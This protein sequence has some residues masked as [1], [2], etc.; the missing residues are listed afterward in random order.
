MS[1]MTAAVAHGDSTT[2][3]HRAAE[4]R[5]RADDLPTPLGDVVAE[6]YRRRAAELELEAW[7]RDA[8]A[9]VAY[10]DAPIAA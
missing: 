4:L 2:L 10:E 3:R 7:A 6:A 8:R 9:G 1:T 5:R